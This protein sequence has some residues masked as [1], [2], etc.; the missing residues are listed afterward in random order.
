MG[1]S[2]HATM[3]CQQ[4]GI[5]REIVDVILE[6]GRRRPRSGAS[7]CFM[8]LASREEARRTL[9]QRRF[10]RISDRLNTYLVVAEDETVI[11]AAKLTSRL[12]F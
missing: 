7:I 5:Q 4:R 12:K 3:R 10:A 8:D 9:G 6:F 11:T 2:Q 1:L